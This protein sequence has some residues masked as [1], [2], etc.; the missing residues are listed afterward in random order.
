MVKTVQSREYVP[1][2][3]KK[4]TNREYDSI[5]LITGKSEKW[6]EVEILLVFLIRQILHYMNI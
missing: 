2:R 6:V 4:N 5:S 1:T 3:W